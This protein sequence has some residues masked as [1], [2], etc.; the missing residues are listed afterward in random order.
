MK[1]KFGSEKGIYEKID[2]TSSSDYIDNCVLIAF[3]MIINRSNFLQLT[4]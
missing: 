1:L 4:T 3:S 2:V